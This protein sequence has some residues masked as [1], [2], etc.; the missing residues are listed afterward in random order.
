MC[1]KRNT[2][3]RTMRARIASRTI[4]SVRWRTSSKGISPQSVRQPSRRR[5]SRRRAPQCS[6][7]RA[8]HRSGCIPNGQCSQRIHR[9]RHK[10]GQQPRIVP[11]STRRRQVNGVLSQD[12]PAYHAPGSRST[13]RN[14]ARPWRSAPWKHSPKPRGIWKCFRADYSA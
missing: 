5:S 9:N 14:R 8:V 10:Q 3:Q 11:Q 12:L 2:S 6:L 4:H 7:H 13:R 1:Q